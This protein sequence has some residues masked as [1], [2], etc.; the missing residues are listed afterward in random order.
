MPKANLVLP[1]SDQANEHKTLGYS[2]EKQFDRSDQTSE[3]QN[4]SKLN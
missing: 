2:K 1:K 4:S 3:Q